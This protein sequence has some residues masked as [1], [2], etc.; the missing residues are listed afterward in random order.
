MLQQHGTVLI[1]RTSL[2]NLMNIKLKTKLA[3]SEA[4]KF[5]ISICDKNIT[6]SEQ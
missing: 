6:I 2:V 4:S 5:I 1:A 3:Q